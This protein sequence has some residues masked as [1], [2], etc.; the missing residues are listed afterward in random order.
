M[1]YID[2]NKD[3]LPETF[4]IDLGNETFTLAFTYNETDDS[5]SVSLYKPIELESDIEPLVLG[6]KMVLN[7][8]LWSD[9]TRL[10]FPAPQL[11]P[12]DLSGVE[13]RISFDNL[14][15]TVFLYIN[16]EGETDE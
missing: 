6:E 16:D 5:F 13:K 9:F 7:K 3:E 10:D 15:N 8:P 1:E 11:V 12:L 4:D 14:G 2:I